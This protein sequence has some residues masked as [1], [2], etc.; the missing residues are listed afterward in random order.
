MQGGRK[1]EM[2]PYVLLYFVL[3]FVSYLFEVFEVQAVCRLSEQA[4]E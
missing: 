4:C 3:V 1:P 2:A